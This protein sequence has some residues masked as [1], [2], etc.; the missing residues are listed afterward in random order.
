MDTDGQVIRFGYGGERLEA[1]T[2]D[3]GW[4]HVFYSAKRTKAE[5]PGLYGQFFHR[6]DE[7]TGDM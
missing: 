5:A 7:K 1:S 6:E 2:G 3:D 4:G